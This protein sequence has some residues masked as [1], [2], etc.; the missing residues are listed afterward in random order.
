MFEEEK[1]AAVIAAYFIDIFTSSVDDCDDIV[2]R[3]LKP[4]ITAVQNDM[5][6][7]IP[8]AAKD[9]MALF[10]IHP[11]KV[12]EPDGFSASFFQSNWET[13]GPA[14]IRE[15]QG[16]F[17]NGSLPHAINSTHIRLIPKISNPKTVADFRPIAFCNVYYKVISKLLS[18][19][20]KHL[21]HYTI[22]ENQSAFIPGRAIADNVLIT[23]EVLHHLKTTK[24][25]KRSSMA[26]KTD[27]SKAYDRLEWRFIKSVLAT[28][29]FHEK[30]ITLILESS[31]PSRT[32][33]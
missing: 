18:L 17:R 16:F 15:I 11:D 30:F 24:A 7:D 6:L 22:S 23:H 26:V 33:S 32:P 21:L 28:L 13:T 27:M 29:G 31:P 4:R 9:K 1:I 2:R 3:A 10:S 8:S 12:P 25:K 20:L 14:M 19:R 5:F